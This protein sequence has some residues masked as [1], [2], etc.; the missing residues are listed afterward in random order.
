MGKSNTPRRAWPSRIV[1]R[2][3]A[4]KGIGCDITASTDRKV[5]VDTTELLGGPRSV[6]C[7]IESTY[8]KSGLWGGSAQ[9][10]RGVRA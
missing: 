6:A 2:A 8:S 7:L 5:L 4:L 10:V 1:P 9:L 3:T